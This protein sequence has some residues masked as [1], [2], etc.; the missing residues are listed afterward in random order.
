[1]SEDQILANQTTEMN[2]GDNESRVAQFHDH[3]RA[4]IADA[5]ANE[6]AI[7]AEVVANERAANETRIRVL[8]EELER[9]RS[10][11]EVTQQAKED[12]YRAFWQETIRKLEETRKETPLNDKVGDG[13]LKIK[14][15]PTFA[16]GVDTLK[17]I[18]WVDQLNAY[19]KYVRD[20]EERK[21]EYAAGL[22]TG[23]AR[24]WY[25]QYRKTQGEYTPPWEEFEQELINTFGNQVEQRNLC[26]RL[27]LCDVK[28]CTKGERR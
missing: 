15:P 28:T 13:K 25:V 1:M 11:F 18:V 2:L 17:I 8:Q 24:Y 4:A 19:F 10:N 23:H 22:L 16:G 12:A 21:T 9:L 26:K 3:I 7:R 5:V 14:E 27:T 20:T 6:R